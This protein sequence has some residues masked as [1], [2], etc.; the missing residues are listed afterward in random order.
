[1]KERPDILLPSTAYLLRCTC[2]IQLVFLLPDTACRMGNCHR[3]QVHVRLAC[4]WPARRI[5]GKYIN[6]YQFSTIIL[7]LSTYMQYGS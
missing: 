6:L 5:E 1:M 2:L 7:S 4:I 3:I